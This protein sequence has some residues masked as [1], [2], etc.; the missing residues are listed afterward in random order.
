MQLRVNIRKLKQVLWLAGVLAFAHA[1]W[2]FYDIYSAKQAGDYNARKL[3]VFEEILNRDIDEASRG[4]QRAVGY[5]AD[6]YNK[7]WESLV[8]GEVRKGPEPEDDDVPPEPA[9]PVVPELS[10][11][12]QAAAVLYSEEPL[13]RFVALTYKDEAGAA[14]QAGK[15]RRLHLSEGDPLKPPYDAAPYNGKVVSIGMQEVKFQWGEG[16]V[17]IRP[18]LGTGGQG[19]PFDQ[20]AP[21]QR[22]DPLSAI[23][24]APSESVQ[25]SPGKWLIG[26]NDIGRIQR[27]PQSFLS[28]ELNVRTITPPGGGRSS[29]E[30][31]DDPPPGSLAA[32][33][34]VKAKD[35]LIS[36]NG[37][38][39]SSMS[40]AANWFKSN[41]NLHEYV[42]VYERAGQEYTTTIYV[43]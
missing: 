24:A 10:T 37:I 8:S 26:T 17:E 40:A 20:F 1:A 41:D 29:L 42:I 9:A 7:L 19:L 38:P 34:G 11:L 36:V 16:E 31:V 32:A 27:D 18:Q 15:L 13:G 22:D 39:L 43:K 21:T 5:P 30:V 35:R 25:L 14:A 4:K 28:T 6:R 12:V 2:T 23:E 33:Y 3:K